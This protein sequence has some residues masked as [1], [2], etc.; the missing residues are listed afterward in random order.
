MHTVVVTAGNVRLLVESAPAERA[1]GEAVRIG[2]RPAD[3]S[4]MV[5]AP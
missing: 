4:L 3:A 2:F 1:S 5:E